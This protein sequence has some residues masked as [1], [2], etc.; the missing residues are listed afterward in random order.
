[1]LISCNGCGKEMRVPDSA[2][3][4]RAKCPKCATLIRIPQLEST[5]SDT[6]STSQSSSK[7]KPPPIKKTRA[8]SIDDDE[9]DDRPPKKRRRR[10]EDDDDEEDD[11]VPRRKKRRRTS[12]SMMAVASMILGLASLFILFV[13]P[14]GVYFIKFPIVF[15]STPIAAVGAIASV[16]LGRMGNKP[17]S[18]VFAWIGMICSYLVLFLVLVV[19]LFFGIALVMPGPGGRRN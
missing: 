4:K 9:D 3:G 2:A 6:Y 10:D 19:V 13:C 1:M 5:D 17:G 7:A 8:S 16:I 12:I 15:V 14:T 18:A 11:D